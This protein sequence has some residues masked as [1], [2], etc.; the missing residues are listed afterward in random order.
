METITE[1][2]LKSVGFK[3]HQLDRQPNK[4]W[5]LWIATDGIDFESLGVEVSL[6]DYDQTWFCW[7]RSDCSHR[8]SRFIHV[9]NLKTRDDLIQLIVGI[10]GQPW[11]PESHFYGVIRSAE[12]ADK[13][14]RTLQREDI[15]SLVGSPAHFKWN[16][17]EKDDTR[18]GA[19][20]EHYEAHEKARP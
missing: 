7:L 13:L 16:E 8:Y 18:G 9:R 12:A 17:I 2:W 20:P 15:K 5:L 1:E 19:L 14:T 3:W 11:N 6:N 10:S 4:H